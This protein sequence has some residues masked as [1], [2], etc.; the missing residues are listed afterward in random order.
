M[1]PIWIWWV[2][3]KPQ[4]DKLMFAL[5]A[6]RALIVQRNLRELIE[7]GA[8]HTFDEEE[9][10]FELIR[11]L[12]AQGLQEVQVDAQCRALHFAGTCEPVSSGPSV[13]L[14]SELPTL[15]EPPAEG[16]KAN[17]RVEALKSL[18]PGFYLAHFRDKKGSITLNQ[19]HSCFRVPGVDYVDYT[20]LGDDIKPAQQ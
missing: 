7:D 17:R 20:F 5:T 3:G 2:V 10:I 14:E 12:L 11:W 6:H 19:L 1:A 15:M 13:V 16:S 18:K 9:S 8:C 4:E